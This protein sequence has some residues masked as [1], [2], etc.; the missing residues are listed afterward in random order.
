MSLLD[1]AWDWLEGAARDAVD[2]FRGIGE[3]VVDGVLTLPLRFNVLMANYLPGV[4]IGDAEYFRPSHPDPDVAALLSGSDGRTRRS[5]TRFQMPEA[6][7]SSS[8][9]AHQD[10]SVCRRSR[11]ATVH[12]AMA[13][14]AG[15]IKVGIS[16][17]GRNDAMIKV[18]GF[19]AGSIIDA[20]TGY[21]PG[22]P[23]MAARPGCEYGSSPY[24]S[25]GGS[26]YYLVLHELGHALGLKHTHDSVPGLPSV[27]A[28]R[29]STEFTV[30]SY[31]T[32][33]DRP[34]TFM[35]YDIAA[36]Q[37]MYGADFTTNNGDTIYSWDASSGEMFIK[38]ELLDQ[39]RIGQGRRADNKIFLTI[40][41]GGGSDTYDMSNFTGNALI[42]LTP[43]GFSR[44]SQGGLARKTDTTFVNGNVYNAFQYQGNVRSLIENAKGGSG[45]DKIIGNQANNI[46]K[47]GRGNDELYGNG[48]HDYLYGEDGDDRF[49]GGAGYDFFDGGKDRD[50]V[51]YW[52]ES[53]GVQVFLWGTGFH[54]GGAAVG[55][56]FV[57]IEAIDGS[58]FN[59]TI[60]GNGDANTFWGDGGDD[61]LRGGAGNDQLSGGDGNDR[62]EG[63]ADADVF[64]GGNGRDTVSYSQ[65]S[66]AVRVYLSD[67]SRNTGEAA[68]DTYVA[69][70]VIEGSFHSDTLEGSTAANTF[71]GYNGHDVLK[72]FG[73]AD[74]LSG[75]AGGDH[76]YGGEGADLLD[77]GADFDF[78]VYADAASG[79]LVD[80]LNMSRNTGEATSDAY[81]S[82][83]GLIGS[84]HADQ[85]YG[86]AGWDGFYGGGGDDRLEGRGGGDQLDGGDGRDHAVYW[87][88]T[89]GV[90]ANLSAGYGTAGDAAGDVFVSIEGLEGSNH[91]DTL[92][93]DGNGNTLYGN[94]GNDQLFGLSGND[95]I[96]G[97]DHSDT[98][99]GG[100]GM[101]CLVGGAGRDYFRFDT[102]IRSGNVDTVEDFSVAEDL[103][104]LSRSVFGDLPAGNTLAATA[105]T[106][107]PAATTSLHRIVYNKA[108][109]ELFYDADGSG[110]AAGQTKFAVIGAGHNL[111]T[112]HFLLV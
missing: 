109:G 43:G 5:R 66:G 2:F 23:V 19:K 106:I 67:T 98:L 112:N 74:T 69:V 79:V 3:W 21:Y 111:S 17:A 73:G 53:A 91:A 27:S 14:V 81:V 1:G 39:Y 37:A 108:T 47:G 70:E 60:E 56:H 64:N 71:S 18:A 12:E 101:D 26:N 30:M 110:M 68:G 87:S 62:L 59:D 13:A 15:Y 84:V 8:I 57:S 49:Y 78:A 45:N 100:D 41:D 94:G 7:M 52:D 50:L 40:W 48:G 88:A 61:V 72:G 76:L 36:L 9:P 103:I 51:S 34:S 46:L 11:R 28:A 63:G 4:S 29:D 99:S 16:Y 6:T 77:G 10:S 58:R 102:A 89:S 20:S 85:F 24:V 31:K 93:G 33:T 96:H 22:V 55:D 86:T 42:D 95:W 80:L 44:F 107:G 32:T 97:G 83:E 25:K 105:F 82:I 75:G 65:A 54:S 38:D 35:Q 90:V 104:Q 92:T